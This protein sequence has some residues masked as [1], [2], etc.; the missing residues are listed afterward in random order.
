MQNVK[1]PRVPEFARND[2]QLF[3]SIAPQHSSLG[4]NETFDNALD[5]SE[6]R[7]FGTSIVFRRPLISQPLV[8][9]TLLKPRCLVTLISNFF[10]GKSSDA[11]DFLGEN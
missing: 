3:H 8:D 10:A 7:A 11:A 1:G 6:K 9:M 4:F 5:S 2:A